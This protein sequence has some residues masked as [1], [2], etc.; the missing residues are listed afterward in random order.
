[1]VG[2]ITALDSTDRRGFKNAS[3]VVRFIFP[4]VLFTAVGILFFSKISREPMHEDEYFFVRRA[5]FF[6][7]FFLKRDFQNPLWF[8]F[9]GID[10]PQVSHYYYGAVLHIAGVKDIK[11][12]LEQARFTEMVPG[13]D[14]YGQPKNVLWKELYQRQYLP[15]EY[16]EKFQLILKGRT[17]AAGLLLLSLVLLLVIL[18][19][20]VEPWWAFAGI[21]AFVFNPITV[22][23]GTKVLGDQVLLLFLLLI[24]LL[25]AKLT[26]IKKPEKLLAAFVTLGI[27]CGLAVGAKLN[28]VVTL[29]F[30]WALALRYVFRSWKS[31]QKHQDIFFISLWSLSP[32][33]VS[34]TAGLVFWALHPLV[35]QNP[36]YG[37]MKYFQFRWRI[38]DAQAR[39]WPD[40]SLTHNWVG[41]LTALDQ[42]LF[43]LPLKI[44]LLLF[45]FGL[46][47]LL[48]TLW[49]GLKQEGFGQ[50]NTYALWI[51]A[52]FSSFLF[53]IPLN[54]ERYFWILVPWVIFSQ[55]V[56]LQYLS[57]VF[58]KRL[59]FGK[60][61]K[62]LR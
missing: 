8:S 11:E 3:F 21:A 31:K 49:L 9:D 17:G 57:E 14:R 46:A 13:W 59:R 51:L 58:Q 19:Q 42:H 28:G 62:L 60:I 29:F 37:F 5:E 24:P 34:L 54:W 7:L 25:A 36:M 10:Q 61:K 44:D 55:V 2:K 27:S 33:V 41:K 50:L 30:L 16:H 4:I 35:W 52:L 56:G 47:L 38:V 43:Y 53:Y 6:D 23:Y 1:M 15:E 18:R 40:S 45:C 39:V 12:A 32:I 20:V 48:R 26:A 22:T